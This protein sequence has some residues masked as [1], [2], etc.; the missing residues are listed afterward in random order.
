MSAKAQLTSSRRFASLQAWSPLC[1]TLVLCSALAAGCAGGETDGGNTGGTSGA[2]GG[3][4]GRGGTGQAGDGP[5]GDG[6]GWNHRLRRSASGSA[7]TSGA[8]APRARPGGRPRAASGTYGGSGGR[9]RPAAGAPGK[10]PGA[11]W[12]RAAEAARTRRERRAVAAAA[13]AQ[14]VARGAAP[15]VPGRPVCPAG[16][17]K[18][19]GIASS[20]YN[21]GKPIS[22]MAASKQRR[23]LL[24]VPT[25]YDNTKPYKLVVA[26]HALNSNDQSVVLPREVLRNAP[27]FEQQHDIRGSQWARKRRALFRQ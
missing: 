22:I 24:N 25:N 11:R 27:P 2:E 9:R 26:Y 17:G 1:S 7:R 18:A 20:M 10:G 15:A 3:T 5:G 23:Y 12:D 16:C 4:T 19:P 13:E 6:P 21:N 14:P 8:S